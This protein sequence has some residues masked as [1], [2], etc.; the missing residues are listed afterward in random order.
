MVSN[1]F[2]VRHY[3]PD[4]LN[5]DKGTKMSNSAKQQVQTVSQAVQ[6]IDA[7]KVERSRIHHYWVSQ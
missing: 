7:R 2:L 4:K 3:L 6:A 5:N 1:V